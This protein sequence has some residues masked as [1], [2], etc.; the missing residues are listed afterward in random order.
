MEEGVEAP[1]LATV[2][3]FLRFYVATSRG[4]IVERPTVDSINTVAEW[5]FAGF[6][7]VT[8]TVTDA[9][10]RS[11]VYHVSCA[12]FQ[13][14]RWIIGLTLPQWV[15]RTLTAESLVVNKRR[16]KH[17][18]AL[19]DL[20]RLLV[21]LWTEDDLIFVHERYRLQ[22]TLIFRMYC[23]TGARLA[24]FFTGGL[25]YGASRGSRLVVDGINRDQDIDLVLQRRG[26]D[27]WKLIY[28]LKQRWVKNNRDPENILYVP[29][30]MP[31]REMRL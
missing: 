27:G 19:R 23:W 31:S 30:L 7:R 2:K 3:D 10:E 18:F 14:E 17:N 20:T 24:A 11:E 22:F 9:N 6:T 29:C 28:Q 12:P 13:S 21:T 26:R 25:R 1:D 5:F 4:K 16:P 8:G 15:R